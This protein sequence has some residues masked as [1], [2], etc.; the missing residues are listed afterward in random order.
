MSYLTLHLLATLRSALNWPRCSQDLSVGDVGTAPDATFLKLIYSEEKNVIETL[1]GSKKVRFS[2]LN[3]ALQQ[4][5][6]AS[7]K[8]DAERTFCLLRLC[9]DRH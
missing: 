9:S 3:T 7:L 1:T 8:K 4:C 2:P 6:K 5:F